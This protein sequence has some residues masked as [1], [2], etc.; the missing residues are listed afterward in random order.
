HLSEPVDVCE[1]GFLNFLR[2]R[3]L[4]WRPLCTSSKKS[5]VG[6]CELKRLSCGLHHFSRPPRVRL[7]CQITGFDRW[8]GLGPTACLFGV[9]CSKDVDALNV[10]FVGKWSAQ[11]SF[12]RFHQLFKI[13]AVLLVYLLHLVLVS[14]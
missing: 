13:R 11:N 14:I 7:D 1:M 9:L 2:L 4:L 3:S 6:F 5:K 12:P 8:I 10:T